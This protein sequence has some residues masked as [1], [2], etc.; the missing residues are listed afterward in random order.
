MGFEVTGSLMFT[1]RL[2][3]GS[4]VANEELF[5]SSEMLRSHVFSC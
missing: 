4:P 5:K 2:H 1:P 3:H